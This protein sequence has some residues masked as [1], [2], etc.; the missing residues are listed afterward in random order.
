MKH[1]AGMAVI[2]AVLIAGC[3]KEEPE[4]TAAKRTESATLENDPTRDRIGERPTA[5][6]ESQATAGLAPGDEPMAMVPGDT[7][8]MSDEE[9]ASMDGGAAD[10]EDLKS[11]V[12]ESDLAAIDA[13]EAVA[14]GAAPGT[15]L[16]QG[17]GLKLAER[18]GCLACHALDRK[19]VGP[20]LNAVAERYRGV[21]NAREQLIAKVKTGGTGNWIGETGGIPMPP[22]SP[23]VP[24]SDIE[25]LVDFVLSL[26]TE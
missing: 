15:V 21:D 18:S 20:A 19:V 26:A 11:N 2:L 8:T 10:T 14:E 24:D 6:E 22:Y 3:S 16:D 9:L 25:Q 4:S 1:V 13:A 7:E 12:T 23:R 17:A 5:P